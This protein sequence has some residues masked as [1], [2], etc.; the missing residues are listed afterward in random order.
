MGSIV[1]HS[2]GLP[3]SL[4]RDPMRSSYL[5][6]FLLTVPAPVQGRRYGFPSQEGTSQI[7]PYASISGSLCFDSLWRP[8]R[9]TPWHRIPCATR[10]A[11]VHAALYGDWPALRL[12][13]RKPL[14]ACVGCVCVCVTLAPC[15]GQEGVSRGFVRPRVGCCGEY[16]SP[17][18]G[19][20]VLF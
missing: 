2:R 8:F 10:R 5:I 11:S 14:H 4:F 15:S 3:L 16:G 19:G 17:Q 1:P 9:P 6:G 18:W 20:G 7:L 12:S 13:G